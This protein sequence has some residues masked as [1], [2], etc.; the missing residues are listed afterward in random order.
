MFDRNV[1]GSYACLWAWQP[2]FIDITC[3]CMQLFNMV[4]LH[5]LLLWVPLY[6]ICMPLIAAAVYSHESMVPFMT[7]PFPE[8]PMWCTVYSTPQ[9]YRQWCPVI[10]PFSPLRCWWGRHKHGGGVCVVSYGTGWLHAHASSL[11]LL[12][13]VYVCTGMAPSWNINL[14]ELLWPMISQCPYSKQTVCEMLMISSYCTG[15]D[16]CI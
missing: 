8:I 1:I 16:V 6:R 3:S 13:I 14:V 12:H 2:M 7:Q 11:A 9:G 4:D 15:H 5:Q 10:C